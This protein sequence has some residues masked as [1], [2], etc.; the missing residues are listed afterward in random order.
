MQHKKQKTKSGSHWRL[1]SV[2]I[3]FHKR[4]T[5]PSSYALLLHL[6]IYGAFFCSSFQKKYEDNK[7]ILV[8]SLLPTK[9]QG[10]PIK[11]NSSEWMLGW[12]VRWIDKMEISLGII[13]LYKYLMFLKLIIS[14]Y[15]LAT[16]PTHYF[17]LFI[18]F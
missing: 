16:R 17:F 7:E 15:A 13:F 10:K 3:F 2:P 12:L 1:F 11:D 6:Y 4:T 9:Q 8:R 18:F 5:S 14:L